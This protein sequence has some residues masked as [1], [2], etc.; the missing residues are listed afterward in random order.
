MSMIKGKNLSNDFWVESISTIVYLK[1][2]ISIRYLYFKTSFEA[3]YF[4]KLAVHN[5]KIFGCKAFAHISKGNINKLD[6]KSIKCIF[7]GYCSKF[8]AYKKNYPS[9][10]RVF[11]SRNVIFH[12]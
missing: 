12:E 9:T 2:R 4:F 1:N 11:A 7:V 5:F 8:K 3:L 6:A 10:Q